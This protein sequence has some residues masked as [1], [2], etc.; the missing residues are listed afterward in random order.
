ML[1]QT[2]LGNIAQEKIFNIVL[3]LLG[4][5]AQVKTLCN[6]FHEAPSNSQQ[7]KIL[8]NVVLIFLKQHCTEETLF[9]VV[10]EALDNSR[11]KKSVKKSVKKYFSPN[12]PIFRKSLTKNWKNDFKTK[13]FLFSSNAENHKNSDWVDE[14]FFL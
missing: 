10:L 14:H 1:S 6:V 4:N 7:E 2:H 11:Q 9:N 3:I 13:D 8:F 5:L 12:S